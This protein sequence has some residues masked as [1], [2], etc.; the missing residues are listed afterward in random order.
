MFTFATILTLISFTKETTFNIFDIYSQCD[1][2]MA[3][4]VCRNYIIYGLV[5]AASIF[6]CINKKLT[7]G[8]YLSVQNQ[9]NLAQKQ[10]LSNKRLIHQLML[11]MFV[12]IHFLP[13]SK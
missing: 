1:N 3:I 11:M 2:S 8:D 9:I 4:G 5:D 7:T 10:V 6:Y 13:N 12:L